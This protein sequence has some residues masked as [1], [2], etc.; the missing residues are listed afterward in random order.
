[1]EFGKKIRIGNFYLLKYLKQ[2][3]PYMKVGTISEIWSMEYGVTHGMFQ[4]LDKA[5]PDE[6]AAIRSI[7]TNMFSTASI[8]DMQ[9]TKD[10][11]EATKRYLESRKSDISDEDD[12]KILESEKEAYIA[13]ENILKLA[14]D[15]K[16]GKEN[17]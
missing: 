9:Y 13:K 5:T 10:V 3:V 7:I 16:E 6:Y 2:E 15:A 8:L 4:L 11:A 14:K 1:M 12:K 17:G